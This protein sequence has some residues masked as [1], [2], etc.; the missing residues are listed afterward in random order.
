MCG[1]SFGAYG[2]WSDSVKF[3]IPQLESDIEYFNCDV[4]LSHGSGGNINIRITAVTKWRQ[5]SEI[6]I[7]NANCKFHSSVAF[8]ALVDI[9][10]ILLR[11]IVCIF[12]RSCPL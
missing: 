6:G 7:Q 8:N 1:C 9:G 4:N 2:V 10:Y 5:S 12:L 11:G 3:L